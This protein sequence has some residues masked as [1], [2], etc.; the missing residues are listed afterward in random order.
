MIDII[1]ELIIKGITNIVMLVITVVFVG[2]FL[3]LLYS[4]GG[5][6][7]LLLVVGGAAINVA[8]EY[9]KKNKGEKK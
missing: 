5:W 3:A 2:G 1:F 8:N 4:L 7:L 6:S 9:D